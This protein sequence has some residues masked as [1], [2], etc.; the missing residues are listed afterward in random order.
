MFKKVGVW[1]LGISAVLGILFLAWPYQKNLNVNKAVSSLKTSKAEAQETSP[2]TPQLFISGGKDY[3]SSGGL[4]ALSSTEEP[5]VQ[6]SSYNLSGEAKIEVYKVG[7]LDLLNFL[8][9]DQ[10]NK[11]IK[12]D[13]DSSH[14]QFVTS[15]KKTINQNGSG[16]N[17]ILPI[18]DSGIWFLKISVGDTQDRAFVVRSHDGLV[19]KEGNNQY[20][21][22]A[23]NFDNGRSQTQGMVRVFNLKD[24][25][26]ELFSAPLNG[27]GLAITK[28]DESADIALLESGSDI[29]VLPINLR[30]LNTYNYRPFQKT[31]TGNDHFLF[32]DRPVYRPGDTLYFKDISRDDNDGILSLPS[33]QYK[34]DVYKDWNQNQ[35]IFEKIYSVSRT[36]S[37][38]G[39]V[40]LPKDVATGDY[41]LQISRPG[42]DQNVYPY[43]NSYASF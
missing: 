20:I 17:A 10:D 28:F 13:P 1:A 25:S 36:G 15:F 16:T 11:Q 23:Q 42:S 34:V 35:P 24:K 30:Y 26:Q 6:I 32:T 9:H 22:W 40:Q 27:D 2:H 12:Q 39:Q 37:L 19:V 14:L 8:L 31:Q 43:E 7:E 18:G 4:I 3:Y 33:G 38:T 29:A 21:F 5:A 41:Q